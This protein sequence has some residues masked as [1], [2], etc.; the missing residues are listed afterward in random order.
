MEWGLLLGGTEHQ[1]DKHSSSTLQRIGNHT[2]QTAW[3][4]SAVLVLLSCMVLTSVA[5]SPSHKE[6]KKPALA[7]VIFNQAGSSNLPL[8]RLWPESNQTS[9][10]A[11]YP[12][13][14][15]P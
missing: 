6:S 10:R 12:Y 15:I 13:S 2:P 11:F 7:P 8:A 9:G 3:Y 5:M 4:S 1:M 14:I